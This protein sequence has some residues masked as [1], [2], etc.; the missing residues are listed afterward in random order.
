MTELRKLNFEKLI[1]V[2]VPDIT[3]YTYDEYKKHGYE[4]TPINGYCTSCEEKECNI[5]KDDDSY[6]LTNISHG[7][8]S[9]DFFRALKVMPNTSTWHHDPILFVYETPSLDYGIYKDVTHK[10]Y[11]KRP[12]KDW[13]WIYKDQEDVAYSECF[14]GGEYGRFI[15]SAI[16]TFKLA[17]VYMTNLVKCGLNN[18]K[19]KFKGLSSYR[20]ETNNNKL[21]FRVLGKRN[22]NTKTKSYFCYGY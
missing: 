5:S 13:Y 8:H 15:L 9:S 20:D 2:G 11:K 1:S 21:L 16:Q 4:H 22:F 6:K 19:G 3:T 17:N 12:S 14:R 7:A 10:G 18:E